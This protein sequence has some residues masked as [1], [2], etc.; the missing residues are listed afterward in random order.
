[1]TE[2]TLTPSRLWRR[3]T[4][5]Q[6]IRAARAFWTDEQAA[7]DQIQAVLLIAQQKKFRPKSVLT[8]EPERKARHLATILS[9]PDALAARCLVVYHLGEQRA[10]MGAFLDAL[11]LK[12]DNGLIEDDDAKPDPEKVPAAVAAI[13][14]KFPAEDV[15][16]YLTTLVCQDPETWSELSKLPQILG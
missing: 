1:M 12:H 5:D 13:A 15:A 8:L 9:L 2:S 16:L 6:R 11:G 14:E 3:M 7:D 10:M 4:A